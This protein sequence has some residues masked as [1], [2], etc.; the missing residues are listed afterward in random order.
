MAATQNDSIND[1]GELTV[2]IT[3]AGA[4]ATGLPAGTYNMEIVQRSFQ[5]QAEPRRKTQDVEVTGGTIT[6]VSKRRGNYVYRLTIIDDFVK[7]ATGELGTVGS[8]FTAVELFWE[9]WVAEAA[10]GALA[11]SPAGGETGMK[12]YTIS[13]AEVLSVSGPA[14]NADANTPAERT[15]EIQFRKDVMTIGDHA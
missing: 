6:T 9:H 14:N 4:A 1:K 10:L 15:V 2:T 7:G 5:P 3:A 13:E 8:E 11:I 12:V